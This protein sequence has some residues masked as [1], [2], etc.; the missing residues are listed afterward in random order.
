YPG[1]EETIRC[2]WGTCYLYGPGEPTPNPKGHPPAHRRETYT[3][4]HETILH[5]GEQLT[6]QPNTP[7]WFQGGPKGCVIWSFST[8]A[9]DVQDIFTDSNVQRQTI[10]IDS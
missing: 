3:V 6:F 2:E 8:K 1:K 10:V 5:P 4:W 7:H 9:I